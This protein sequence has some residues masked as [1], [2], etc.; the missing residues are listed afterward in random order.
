MDLPVLILMTRTTC[1]ACVDLKSS[2]KWA[3]LKNNLRNRA[4]FVV[5]E[6]TGN[7]KFPEVLPKTHW[8]PTIMLANPKSYYKCFTNN[9]KIN[10]KGYSAD[11]TIKGEVY[12]SYIENGEYKI[13]STPITVPDIMAWYGRVERKVLEMSEI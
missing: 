13:A 11:Y 6:N 3:Y 8:L 10:E 7:D 2:G 4:R 1:P 5:F 9:D 12:G